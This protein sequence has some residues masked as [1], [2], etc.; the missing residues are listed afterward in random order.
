MTFH[1][2]D[3]LGPPE[4]HGTVSSNTLTN[5]RASRCDKARLQ[6]SRREASNTFM[7]VMFL[8]G[9][10][11]SGNRLHPSIANAKASAIRKSSRPV[12]SFVFIAIPLRPPSN[13]IVAANNWFTSQHHGAKIT[14]LIVRPP[15]ADCFGNQTLRQEI[16]LAQTTDRY[17]LPFSCSHAQPT[18]SVNV[19]IACGPESSSL[20]RA[21]RSDGT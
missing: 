14:D 16:D 1:G 19:Q 2:N 21:L 4:R 20:D 7:L 11:T 17:R 13:G 3:P 5:R 9:R 18:G 6:S 12:T 10:Y 15:S 8:L